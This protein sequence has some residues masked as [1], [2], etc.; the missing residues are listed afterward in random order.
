MLTG[1]TLASSLAWM[2]ILPAT[3]VFAQSGPMVTP[4]SVTLS[5][6]TTSTLNGS[7]T[8]SASA[9]DPNGT[10]EYQFWVEEPNGQWMDAQNYSTSNTFTLSTP[11]AG[12]YL[13][14]VDVMDKTE[15]AAGQWNLAQTTL[16]DGVFVD[17]SVTVTSNATGS[18]AKGTPITLTA[19]ASNIYDPVYQFWVETP[20]GE[21]MQSGNY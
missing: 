2:S 18:V 15:V 17:S 7:A 12:D 16:S 21:W 14:A 13:V 3:A 9:Q 10:A 11:S 6:P 8:F 5:G 19:T 1:L 4:G 20:S